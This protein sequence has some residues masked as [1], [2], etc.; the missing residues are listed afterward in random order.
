MTNKTFRNI[1]KKIDPKT[2]PCGILLSISDQELKVVSI[3]FL[4]QQITKKGPLFIVNF[5]Q[6]QRY[7]ILVIMIYDL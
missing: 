1:F 3:F 4:C 7:L 6:N 2:E 5:Y